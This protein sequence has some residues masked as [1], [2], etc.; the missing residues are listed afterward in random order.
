[1]LAEPG[2]NETLPLSI[3]GVTATGAI[4][5][6]EG[7]PVVSSV[8]SD[9]QTEGTSLV[10]TVTLSGASASATTYA[11]SLSGVDATAGSDFTNAPVFSNGVTLA[12]GVLTV[13]AGVTS[14][15]VT[16]PTLDDVLAES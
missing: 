6:N 5:D 11:F 8:T 15:T 1:M 10:H 13:P 16:V 3:G 7:A 9:A 12:G 4:I 14:F 2:A